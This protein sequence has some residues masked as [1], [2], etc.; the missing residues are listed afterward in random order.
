MHLRCISRNRIHRR[1]VSCRVLSYPLAHPSAAVDLRRHD[2]LTETEGK[3]L[4]RKIRNAEMAEKRPRL[5]RFYARGHVF[6]INRARCLTLG[7]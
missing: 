7:F 1:P 3:A 5:G 4:A 6:V 2:M